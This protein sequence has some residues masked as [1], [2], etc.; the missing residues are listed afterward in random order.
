M[1]VLEISMSIDILAHYDI[2][3]KDIIDQ[4]QLNYVKFGLRLEDE[5]VV[6]SYGFDV[7]IID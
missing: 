6:L 5:K 4:L 2:N 3:I 1:F 7:N